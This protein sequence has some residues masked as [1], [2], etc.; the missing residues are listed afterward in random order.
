MKYIGN[1]STPTKIIHSENDL[2]CDI[3][4]AEQVYT[5]LK[6]Q[7]V[8]TEFIRYPDES[9]DLSRGG[10]TDRRI[11][12]LEHISQWFDKYLK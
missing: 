1:V 9:H 5:A 7:E 2:R 6:Y 4:Q 8:D 10:R 11:S 3:E 12:R